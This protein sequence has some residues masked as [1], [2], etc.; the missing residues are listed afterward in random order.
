MLHA[1]CL[2]R[3][4]MSGDLKAVEEVQRS[5]AEAKK[6][7]EQAAQ[8]KQR[9]IE[10]A[11]TKAD[12]IVKEAE[13][14]ARAQ[15]EHEVERVNEDIASKKAAEAKSIKAEANEVRAMRISNDM[16]PELVRKAVK[17]IIGG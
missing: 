2:V 11:R 10:S 1:F 16:I 15:I 4:E 9:Y 5:E 7:V 3:D 12:E 14:Q 17:I 6:R 8:N 13:V